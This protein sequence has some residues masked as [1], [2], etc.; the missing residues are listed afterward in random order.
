MSGR[1][2]KYPYT[3][4]AKLG[5]FPWKHH[6]THSWLYR[7]YAIGVVVSIPA[8][9]WLNGKS[10]CLIFYPKIIYLMYFFSQSIHLATSRNTRTRRL[11]KL[12]WPMITRLCNNPVVKN[13]KIVMDT[14][15][16]TFCLFQISNAC[17]MSLEW[18]INIKVMY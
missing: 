18:C 5:M 16:M 12:L 4:S 17:G 8:F 9:M 11:K 1:A 14:N 7:Y 3:L 2:M 15:Y 6:M 10:N 13:L